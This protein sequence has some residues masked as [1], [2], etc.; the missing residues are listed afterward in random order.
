MHPSPMIV[1]S[2]VI[3]LGIAATGL[4][5]SDALQFLAGIAVAGFFVGYVFGRG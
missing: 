3:G 1:T 5:A 4:A 2:A